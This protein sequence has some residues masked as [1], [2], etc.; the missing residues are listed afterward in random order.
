MKVL[1][2]GDTLP[3]TVWSCLE[4]DQKSYLVDVRTEQEWST[5]GIPDLS[6]I[7]KK[8]ILLS[9]KMLP[10]MVVNHMFT[11]L[12]QIEV[13]DLSSHI[14][15]I[16]RSGVR[17]KE[18]AKEAAANGYINSYNVIDG[19]EGSANGWVSSNLPKRFY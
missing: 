3:A 11:K 2:A 15:F 7:D 8:L 19:F 12:L 18:A 5:V 17:S 16:C 4:S 13:P 9:W 14:F 1:Y 6:S 10:D